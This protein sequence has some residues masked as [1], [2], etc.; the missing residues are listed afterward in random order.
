MGRLRTNSTLVHHGKRVDFL[1]IRHRTSR[2]HPDCTKRRRISNLT[3]GARDRR[4]VLPGSPRRCATPL[5][6]T[7]LL[8]SPL[9]CWAGASATATG[10]RARGAMAIRPRRAAG[11]RRRLSAG[12]RTLRSAT[13]GTRPSCVRQYCGRAF[14]PSLLRRPAT[15]SRSSRAR[16]RYRRSIFDSR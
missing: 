16:A 2:W 10:A 8:S 4:R 9:S 5:L 12:V 13:A 14:T 15:P 1:P 11:R 7:L 6:L 3:R